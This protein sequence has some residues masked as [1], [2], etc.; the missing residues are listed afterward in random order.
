M[1]RGRE[2][3]S[4]LVSVGMFGLGCATGFILRDELTMPT[5]LRI[6]MA[7]VEHSILTRR[8]LDPE[9]IQMLD[10]NAH[11]NQVMANASFAMRQHEK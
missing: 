1:F 3:I 9:M 11:K 7:T 4:P 8:K 10:P 5:Y 2:S 6:K